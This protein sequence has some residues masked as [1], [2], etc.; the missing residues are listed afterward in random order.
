[1]WCADPAVGLGIA[2][3]AIYEGGE[4]GEATVAAPVPQSPG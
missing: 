3:L 4:T 2:A 1:V